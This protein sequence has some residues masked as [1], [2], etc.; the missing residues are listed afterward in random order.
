LIGRETVN[1][2][3][4]QTLAAYRDHGHPA[5]RIEQELDEAHALLEKLAESGVHLDAVSG[6]LEAEGVQK[7]IVP[8]DKLLERLDQRRLEIAS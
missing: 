2:M 3:P 1:T 6:Q 5:L 4:P 8:Y 7:F